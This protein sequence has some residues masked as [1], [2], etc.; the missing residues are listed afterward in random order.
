MRY[1]ISEFLTAGIQSGTRDEGQGTAV[2]IQPGTRDRE[3]PSL[4]KN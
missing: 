2:G 3:Q 1:E 4:M